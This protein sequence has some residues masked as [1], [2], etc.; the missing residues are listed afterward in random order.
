VVTYEEIFKLTAMTMVR[1]VNQLPLTHTLTELP[2][3][4]AA[5]E[6]GIRVSNPT[7][8]L[9]AIDSLIRC[10]LLSEQHPVYMQCK[11]LIVGD[12]NK[13][14]GI[15][16]QSL[17]LQKLWDLLDYPHMHSKIIDLIVGFSQFFP[18]DFTETVKRS[19]DS[20]S[21]PEK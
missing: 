14:S 18:Y 4:F 2:K 21:D 19:F 8:S 3:W 15:D 10:L 12:K 17:A 7:I 9:A 5:I 11:V 20:H 6:H 13:N 16:Y 1:I